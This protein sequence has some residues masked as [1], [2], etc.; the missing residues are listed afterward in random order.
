MPLGWT[1]IRHGCTLTVVP[2]RSTKRHLFE[3]I[4]Q[5]ANR[6]PRTGKLLNTSSNSN[7]FHHCCD[8]SCKIDLNSFKIIDSTKNEFELRF[9][10]SLYIK[11]L[12]PSLNS[13]Q[14]AMPLLIAWC[15]ITCTFSIIVWIHDYIM[16][17]SR[18]CF[19]SLK[20]P[21]EGESFD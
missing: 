7:I 13:D 8:C 16:S 21:Q 17:F 9:L 11:S 2:K 4:A 20:M 1:N 3:R 19:H 6:S 12:K 10:E 18:I 14:S 15:N 5:H